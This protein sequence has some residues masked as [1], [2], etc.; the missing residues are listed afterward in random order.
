VAENSAAIALNTL[1]KTGQLK[2]SP[3]DPLE[4]ER[5]LSMAIRRLADSK[6]ST[7]SLEGRFLAAYQA[8]HAGALAALR[9]HGFRSD[10]RFFVIQCFAHTLGWPPE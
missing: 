6:I 3:C 1:A 9:L 4:V 5:M 10:N 7:Q 2:A 8:A